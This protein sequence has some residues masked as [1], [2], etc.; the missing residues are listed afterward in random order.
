MNEGSGAIPIIAD[1]DVLVAGGGP[2][3]IAA[4][5]E[6]AKQGART[7]IVERYGYLGGMITGAD[8]LAIIGAGNGRSQIARGFTQEVHDRMGRYQEITPNKN[9]DFRVDRE[10]FKWQAAEM[11]LESG[12]EVFFHS[13]IA[14]PVIE[15]GRIRG[16]NV[17]TKLGRRLIKAKVVVDATADADLVYRA[18][19]P[20]DDKSHDVTLVV[21]VKGIDTEKVEAFERE[22]P[23][24]HRE[25]VEKAEAINGGALPGKSRYLRG[26]DVAD[27]VSLSRAEIVLRRECFLA[28]QHLKE[29]HPGYTSAYVESTRDQI[30]VRQGRRIVGRYTF[31]IEDLTSSRHFEDGVARLG[32]YLKEYRNN[33]SIEGLNYD[34]PYRSLIPVSTEG[35]VVA[36][37][38]ISCDYESCNSLRLLVPCFATGQAAGAAAALAA[39][40]GIP[41]SELPSSKLREVLKG[42][43]VYLG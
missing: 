39:D 42:R 27:P 29:H 1:V 7:V 32:A 9:G 36:G 24:K 12:V 10:L 13:W 41:P 8:V 21:R 31:T 4:A 22:F 23:D 25:I 20:C 34:I 15:D 3:G 19:G 35:V 38:S 40:R 2:A 30:G 14:D 6:V 11:L 16:A 37:R 17:E 18:G 28:L 5:Y 26:V 33:Y 43:G